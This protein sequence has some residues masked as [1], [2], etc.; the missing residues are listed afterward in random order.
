M[1]NEFDDQLKKR[2]EEIHFPVDENHR[3]EMIH[4][5]NQPKRRKGV[6]FWWLGGIVTIAAISGLLLPFNQSDDILNSEAPKGNI[7][8][9]E[10]NIDRAELIEPLNKD[11]D[12]DNT[13][14]IQR[15]L[16]H[17]AANGS[18]LKDNQPRIST[19]INQTGNTHNRNKDTLAKKSAIASNVPLNEKAN[20]ETI[21]AEQGSIILK[22]PAEKQL[23]GKEKL[24]L[25]K[26]EIES[27]PV[28][29]D[30]ITHG[31]E[32]SII[33][34]LEF[35]GEV[36]ALNIEPT[37]RKTHP[38]HLFAEGGLSYIPSSLPD[39]KS[40]WSLKAGGGIGYGIFPKTQIMWS[41]GYMMQ[42]DGFSFERSSTVN[43]LG[44]GARSNFH[45][46]TPDRLHFVYSKLGVR[47]NLRRHMLSAAVGA[48]WIYGA[49]GTIVI[50]TQ[51]QLPS[52]ATESTQYAW[53]NLDGMQRLL[54]SGEISYGY[55]LTPRI[56][57][58][59]GLRH[60]FTSLEDED[61][62]L[63][64]EG[65]YWKGKFAPMNPSFTINYRFY[66]KK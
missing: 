10:L 4:L 3:R 60:Y 62:D 32:S 8:L 63:A 57:L 50:Q 55:H 41:A 23:T 22:S 24:T 33:S 36:L 61:P 19:K 13:D 28:S 6:F 52:M 34:D 45:T 18:T 44:F 21:S 56:S 48:Q 35:S 12:I 59:M 9:I 66:E 25:A 11:A 65:Y 1:K 43:E 54:W 42:K 58:H 37:F 17:T 64:E 38:I 40:G 14:N 2:W 29:N 26:S 31:I 27:A 5:L 30:H 7:P 20:I 51:Q 49:Q 53:L 46:L 16:D 39:I 15:E 47:Q